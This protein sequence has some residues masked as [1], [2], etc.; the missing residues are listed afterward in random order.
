MLGVDPPRARPHTEDRTDPSVALR[1]AGCLDPSILNGPSSVHYRTQPAIL[2]AQ[3][4]RA[5]DAPGIAG[6]MLEHAAHTAHFALHYIGATVLV[7]DPFD[8]DTDAYWREHWGLEPSEQ[9]IPGNRRLKRLW[10]AIPR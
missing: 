7:V 8:E 3:F 4:A 5:A 1:G 2:L 6:E 10:A 9:G